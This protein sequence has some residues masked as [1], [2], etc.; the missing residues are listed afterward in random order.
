[1][2]VRAGNTRVIIVCGVRG[3]EWWHYDKPRG[4]LSMSASLFVIGYGTY[5]NIFWHMARYVVI[6]LVKTSFN[7]RETERYAS[8]GADYRAGVH[9][10]HHRVFLHQPQG[11][12]PKWQLQV[13]RQGGR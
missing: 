8:R 13:P 5:K 2:N 12:V 1:M 10:P 4:A 11:P 6:L 9:E 3:N 7:P